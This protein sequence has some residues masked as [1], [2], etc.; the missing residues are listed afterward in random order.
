MVY[1]KHPTSLFCMWIFSSSS[2][3][4]WKRKLLS[5]VPLLATPWNS[6]QARTLK[7]V[8]ILFSRASSQPRGG[9]ELCNTA[10]GFFTS[11]KTVLL[12]L[13]STG[14][15]VENH[16]TIYERVY[17]WAL[18]FTP[19]ICMLV[20]MPVPHYV[21]CYSFIISFEIRSW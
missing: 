7:W 8:A 15:F 14:T 18:Y 21:D 16:L 4:C 1:C 13:N 6:L 9:I 5:R 20:F 11:S 19:L 2:T 17:F 3:V 12:P 10:S